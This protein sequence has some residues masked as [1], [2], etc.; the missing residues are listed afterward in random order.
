MPAITTVIPFV[1]LVFHNQLYDLYYR[2]EHP[3]FSTYTTPQP[4]STL[5]AE[6]ESKLFENS[7]STLYIDQVKIFL[8]SYNSKLYFKFGEM[9]GMVETT[10]NEDEAALFTIQTTPELHEL[11]Q[12][13]LSISN[14]NDANGTDDVTSQ[15]IM[16]LDLTKEELTENGPF[17]LHSSSEECSN[18]LYFEV[19]GKSTTLPELEVLN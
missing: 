19:Y 16:K 9:T 13:K 4:A 5:Y 10:E 1:L 8:N 18:M 11:G 12:F 15:L 14:E 3:G 6:A 17:A 2:A 7:S